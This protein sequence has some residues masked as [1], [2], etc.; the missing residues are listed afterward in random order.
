MKHKINVFHISLVKTFKL[1][2]FPKRIQQSENILVYWKMRIVDGFS[3]D[4][5]RTPTGKTARNSYETIN[6]DEPNDYV[7]MVLMNPKRQR[8]CSCNRCSY[9]NIYIPCEFLFFSSEPKRTE[10]E[11]S[12]FGTDKAHCETVDSINS[13]HQLT[14]TAAETKKPPAAPRS[15]SSSSFP[16]SLAISAST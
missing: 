8:R 4:R 12:S 10:T 9:T 11:S 15:S 16:I 13:I 5:T 3:R 7:L 14:I 1:Q 2:H 6:I